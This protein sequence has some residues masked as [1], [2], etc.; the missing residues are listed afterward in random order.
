MSRFVVIS[1]ALAGKGLSIE[2]LPLFPARADVI[3]FPMDAN[4]ALGAL[5]LNDDRRLAHGRAFWRI[6]WQES[7]G[8]PAQLGTSLRT[9]G[10]L[11]REQPLRRRCGGSLD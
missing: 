6:R 1:P 3:D 9:S 4:P 8:A 2:R 11:P 10:L 5:G 7:R